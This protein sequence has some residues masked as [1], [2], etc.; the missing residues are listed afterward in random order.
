MDE[1]GNV[2][3]CLSRFH[4]D[5]D[6]E[7]ALNLTF[8][9][10]SEGKNLTYSHAVSYREIDRF[11]IS[12]RRFLAIAYTDAYQ[13]SVAGV[14]ADFRPNNK[15]I[16]FQFDGLPVQIR[17]REIDIISRELRSELDLLIPNNGNAK[18]KY[19]FVGVSP[20]GYRGCYYWYLD[21]MDQI[22]PGEYVWVKMGRHNT[23]QV[24]FVDGVL[25]CNDNDAPYDI[26]LVKRVLRR[27][28][29]KEIQSFQALYESK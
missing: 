26:N 4:N 15:E 14:V 11:L 7:R 17:E 16:V 10:K 12:M 24:V 5:F 21:C 8:Y 25:L 13:M 19:R 2:S 29:E 23:E 6:G 28:T 1:N 22:Q 20:R 9:M 3:L 18:G 27:A